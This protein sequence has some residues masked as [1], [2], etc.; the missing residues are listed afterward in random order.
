MVVR[1]LIKGIIRRI[2]FTE[3]IPIVK[4]AHKKSGQEV[5]QQSDTDLES[6]DTDMSQSPQQKI[7]SKLLN[8]RYNED[9]VFYA[10]LQQP[11]LRHLSYV[12]NAPVI[13]VSVRLTEIKRTGTLTTYDNTDTLVENSLVSSCASSIH[14]HEGEYDNNDYIQ[15]DDNYIQTDDQE[16]Y[17]HFINQQNERFDELISNN[18]AAELLPDQDNGNIEDP[19]LVR[20]IYKNRTTIMSSMTV[21]VLNKVPV[22]R[23]YSPWISRSNSFSSKLDD[24]AT[25]NS[26]FMSDD[27]DGVFP[28]TEFDPVFEDNDDGKFEFGLNDEAQIDT[29]VKSLD[30]RTK[31]G[32][33]SFLKQDF[34]TV[35]DLKNATTL[36]K[37]QAFLIISI[38]LTIVGVKLFIPIC[39]YLYHKFRNNQLY[40]FNNNNLSSLW[41]YILKFMSYLEAKLDT[42]GVVIEKIS[43]HDYHQSEAQLDK[44]Y[45]EFTTYTSELINPKKLLDKFIPKD[46]QLTRSLFEYFLNNLSRKDKDSYVQDPKYSMYFSNKQSSMKRSSTTSSISGNG[47][48]NFSDAKQYFET[49]VRV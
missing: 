18:I 15:T 46:D 44:L 30:D 49:P 17:R 45:Q 28:D 10:D 38:K 47:G 32:L 16:D 12:D 2:P 23:N 48:N 7:H 43:Q 22:L 41:D 31:V 20:F 4:G 24:E 25:L 33:Y 40:F 26:P 39:K 21:R 35:N 36:D 5:E 19:S 8:N 6:I 9:Q 13:P 29:F 3:H 37:I 1:S 14:M 11:R 42:H 27:N 34:E